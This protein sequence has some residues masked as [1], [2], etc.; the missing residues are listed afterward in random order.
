MKLCYCSQTP[1]IMIQQRKSQGEW[2]QACTSSVCRHFQNNKS[3]KVPKYR[4]LKV[5]QGKQKIVIINS[6]CQVIYILISTTQKSFYQLQ[7]WEYLFLCSKPPTPWIGPW[8]LWITCLNLGK[9][10]T[11]K[12]SFY[13]MWN[14]SL[15]QCHYNTNNQRC[16]T[17]LS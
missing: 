5:I 3:L 2:N 13:W 1:T 6:K 8:I 7:R 12:V 16:D 10:Q 11:Q 14:F 4:L 17:T 15:P 9:E